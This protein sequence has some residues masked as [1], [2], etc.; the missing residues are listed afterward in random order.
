MV[1]VLP[2]VNV[3]KAFILGF[4]MVDVLFCG[5]VDE[6]FT[7]GLCCRMNSTS[8]RYMIRYFERLKL[9]TKKDKNRE[10]GEKRQKPRL[11]TSLKIGL[12]GN[13]GKT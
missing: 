9:H 7:L 4:C 3:C 2:V 5:E 10:K 12:R 6:Y 13:G 1:W 8:V 11:N